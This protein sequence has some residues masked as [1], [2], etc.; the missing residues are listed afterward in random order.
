M[1]EKPLAALLLAVAAPYAALG[2]P[3]KPTAPPKEAPKKAAPEAAKKEEDRAL[4]D[5]KESGEPTYVDADALT[6][7]TARRSFVYT[8]NVKVTQ[9]DMTLT[10]HLLEGS[11]TEDNKIRELVAKKN[12]EILKGPSIRATSNRAV[13]DAEQETVTL[14]ENPQL[15]QEGSVLTADRVKVYMR[16]N[17]SVAEG[18]VRMKLVKQAGPTPAPVPTPV[19]TYSP[20]T[21]KKGKR[22]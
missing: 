3:A 2:A 12:V 6:L 7:D 13:Y 9:G 10:S 14:L 15:Y 18:Q 22:S 20:G 17:K 11:Y 5:F 4:F 8:G 19:P 1:L 21:S 16:T